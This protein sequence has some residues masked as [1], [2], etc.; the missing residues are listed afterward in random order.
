MFYFV[1]F[2]KFYYAHTRNSQVSGKNKLD[3][4]GVAQTFLRLIMLFKFF[5]YDSE[6]CCEICWLCNLFIYMT[7]FNIYKKSGGLLTNTCLV[8]IKMD[9]TF[10]L[11]ILWIIN[12]N[13]FNNPK[14]LISL[15]KRNKRR[16]NVRVTFSPLY[17]SWS[18]H[19]KLL[20]LY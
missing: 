14:K 13:W 12:C 18:T 5:I 6:Q 2:N 11:E 16:L 9:I 4:R 15:R 1:F 19:G 17:Q 3:W 10:R 7:I 20:T 8:I